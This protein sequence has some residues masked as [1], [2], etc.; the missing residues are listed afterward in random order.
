MWSGIVF[1]ADENGVKKN[2]QSMINLTSVFIVSINSIFMVLMVLSIVYQKL[3]EKPK[4]GVWFEN[5]PCFGKCM[6]RCMTKCV[7]LVDKRP[8]MALRAERRRSQRKRS[9]ASSSETARSIQESTRNPMRSVLDHDTPVVKSRRSVNNAWMTA[10]SLQHVSE[11]KVFHVQGSELLVD[12]DHG[13][14]LDGR[15]RQSGKDD[16][17]LPAGWTEH[18]S[19]KHEK[20][21]YESTISGKTQWD[22][23]TL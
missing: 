20:H 4:V 15:R 11:R 21:Y 23:P 14:T 17:E 19:A 12:E 8:L 2:D 5:I 1:E 22:F 16:R 6:F 7:P 9:N 3:I 18:Y 13:N 10:G